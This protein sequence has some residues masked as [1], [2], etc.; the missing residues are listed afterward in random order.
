MARLPRPLPPY[1]VNT[2]RY[3]DDDRYIE[4]WKITI[5]NRIDQEWPCNQV[6]ISSDPSPE[7]CDMPEH[8]PFSNRCLD[9]GPGSPV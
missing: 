5:L 1:D 4:Q 3:P 2:D 7:Y 9:H 6:L 8:D